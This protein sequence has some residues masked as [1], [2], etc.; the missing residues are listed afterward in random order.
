MDLAAGTAS[1]F[2]SIAGI[3]NVTG[4]SGADT[5]RAN[6]NAQIN[7]LAGGLGDDTYFADNGDTITEAADAGTDQVFTTSATFTLAAN[8]ENLTFT[9]AATSMAPATGRTTSSPAMAAPMCSTAAAA[10][11][12]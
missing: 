3:E 6:G 10:T 7:N 11:I 1:G 9:G 5:L 4:G 2:S 12:P 8:V